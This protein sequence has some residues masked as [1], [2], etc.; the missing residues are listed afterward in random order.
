[1]NEEIRN[2]EALPHINQM[3]NS[4]NAIDAKYGGKVLKLAPNQTN[5]VNIGP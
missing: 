2:E 3:K 1:M 5:M 4:F